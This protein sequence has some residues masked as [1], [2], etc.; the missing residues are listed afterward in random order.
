MG[1]TV[2]L[3]LKDTTSNLNLIFLFSWRK[4]LTF[5]TKFPLVLI[6]LTCDPFD[7]ISSLASL[8]N[9]LISKFIDLRFKSIKK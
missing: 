6:S 5:F 1:S 4:S 8:S 2:L 3:S 7:L 9:D